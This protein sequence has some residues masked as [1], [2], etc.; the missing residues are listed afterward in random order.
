MH[1]HTT[2]LA[3]TFG[4]ALAALTVAQAAHSA[5]SVNAASSAPTLIGT[6]AAGQQYTVTTTGIADLF[7]GFNGLGLTF[8]ADGLPTYAFAAPYATFFPAGLSYDPS[9]GP[10]NFGVGGSGQLLGA[11]L[12]TFTAAPASPAAYFSIGLGTTFTAASSGSLYAVVNDTFYGDNGR[13]YAVTLSAV[14][15][16]GSAALLLPGLAGLA[17]RRRRAA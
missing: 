7:V 2:V 15:E 8:T 13:A 10:T 4:L 16:S 12:G 9:V 5:V 1:N 6:V 14:P 3:R 11:L 17:L